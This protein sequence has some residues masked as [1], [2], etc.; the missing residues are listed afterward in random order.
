MFIFIMAY[1]HT[2]A[3]SCKCTMFSVFIGTIY[4]AFVYAMIA[5]FIQNGQKVDSNTFLSH[6]GGLQNNYLSNALK[7]NSDREEMVK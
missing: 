4:I 5:Y 2:L 6:V 3:L 7:I 1:C